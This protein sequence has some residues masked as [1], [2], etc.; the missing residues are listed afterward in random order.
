MKREGP[1]HR[2]Q[3]LAGSQVKLN[4]AEANARNKKLRARRDE[5]EELLSDRNAAIQMQRDHAVILGWRALLARLRRFFTQPIRLRRRRSIPVP[6]FRRTE[7]E[8]LDVA[9]KAVA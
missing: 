1:M 4:R 6:A 2:R 7:S 5:L 8:I 3:Y 9:R